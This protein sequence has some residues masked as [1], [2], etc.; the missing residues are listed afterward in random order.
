MTLVYFSLAVG[1]A[2]SVP[3]HKVLEDYI[4]EGQVSKDELISKKIDAAKARATAR[5]LKELLGVM[6]DVDEAKRKMEQE[7]DEEFVAT[8]ARA[9]NAAFFKA[10]EHQIRG[11]CGLDYAMFLPK[12]RPRKLEKNEERKI[13]LKWDPLTS[14]EVPR[15]IITNTAT[16]K[17][18]FEIPRLVR[19]GVVVFNILHGVSDLGSLGDPAMNWY[20][21]GLGADGTS[22]WD[23]PHRI[24]CDFSGGLT[25]AGLTV[26]RFEWQQVM[27]LR[28]GPW[29]KGGNHR[30]LQG[31][32]KDY[33]K[34]CD[35]TNAIFEFLYDD[36]CAVF[37][38]LGDHD[39]GT[40][41]HM[42]AVFSRVKAL[43]LKAPSECGIK[44]GRWWNIEVRGQAFF[45]EKGAFLT[46]FMLLVF[47]GWRRRWWTSFV[48]SPLFTIHTGV[49]KEPGG[50]EVVEIAEM[51]EAI[52]E[53]SGD[54]KELHE[55]LGDGDAAPDAVPKKKA[56]EE[57]AKLKSKALHS[58]HFCAQVMGRPLSRRIFQGQCV[59]SEP[60]RD[61]FWEDL[62]LMSTER[63]GRNLHLDLCK[64][65]YV[66]TLRKFLQK[67]T[68]R[69]FASELGLL[70]DDQAARPKMRG[71]MVSGK[72]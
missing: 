58:L 1:F 70:D 67:F 32:A 26:G 62:E 4:P 41:D 60:L 45:S 68:S 7:E 8:R 71:W 22:I 47:L 65:S 10:S 30:V 55:L 54:E 33:F 9:A 31:V 69:Q 2:Q 72:R 14:K 49:Y 44:P 61:S 50:K 46:T 40:D 12:V 66:E 38:L 5:G 16:G 13:V 23:R 59:L 3:A 57:V 11:G 37:D 63:G 25:E 19:D 53:G 48:N 51:D 27:T 42:R 6:T 24:M 15:S 21:R 17:E 36:F 18:W 64:G 56:R 28:K 20:F 52:E 35:H 39:Y 43:A 34:T 29:G